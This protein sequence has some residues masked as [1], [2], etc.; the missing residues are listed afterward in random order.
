MNKIYGFIFS[1][2]VCNALFSQPVIS[3]AIEPQV[4]DSFSFDLI[5]ATGFDTGPTGADVVWD[6]SG[7]TSVS[8][9][10][11]DFVSPSETPYEDMFP[12]A[13]I[14]VQ[15]AAGNYAFYGCTA[16]EMS[17]YGGANSGTVAYYD[18]PEVFFEFP[19]HYGDSYS[20]DFHSSFYSGVD[21]DR[22]G[23]ASG[24]VDG[25]GTLVLPSGTYYNV[26]R[27][28]VHEDYSDVNTD[29]GITI[30]YLADDYYW[31]ME[32]NTLALFE[33]FDITIDYPTPTE[34]EVAHL[35]TNITTGVNDHAN[36]LLTV[37]PNPAAENIFIRNAGFAAQNITVT[38]ISGRTV[39]SEAI[40]EEK[41]FRVDVSS[42]ASGIYTVAVQTDTGVITGKFLKI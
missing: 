29:F 24:I 12:G 5:D 16:S 8:S 41:L 25:Y 1:A 2:F 9:F 36:E 19:L 31:F 11:E 34:T 20:D 33:Y 30:N 32:G 22:S 18:D 14:A 23:S 4:G 39:Y 3:S 28:K 6:F 27:V 17:N 7:V 10:T 26:L 13:T 42:F 21:I 38:D 35:N 40:P 37:F 15:S